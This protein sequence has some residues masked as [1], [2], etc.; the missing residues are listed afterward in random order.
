[1]SSEEQHAAD[2]KR[3]YESSKSIT[4]E[5]ERLS[6]AAVATINQQDWEF[7]KTP[8]S[9]EVLE[10]V[11]PDYSAHFDNY[12][13][14]L[15]FAEQV[16][17]HRRLFEENP[18]AKYEIQSISTIIA[19]GANEASVFMQIDIRGISDM[20]VGGFSEF[21]WRREG[22]RWVWYRDIAMRGMNQM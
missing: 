12:P 7:A 18:K 10:H 17:A 6:A 19:E 20:T 5:L 13:G 3:L 9:R 11:A 15:S 1:M 2:N 4:A 16:S 21:R 14:K 8:Q 22:H